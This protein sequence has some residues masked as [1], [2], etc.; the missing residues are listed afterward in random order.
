M[1]G[2]APSADAIRNYPGYGLAAIT[3]THARTLNQAVAR[4]PLPEEPA[5]G[6]VYGQE[7]RG[8]TGGRLRDGAIW[9]VIPRQAETG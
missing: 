1:I 3:A 9:A 6:V 7:K 4:Y 8:G 5:H 2:N